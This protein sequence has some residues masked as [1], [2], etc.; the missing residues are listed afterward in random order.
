M[1]NYVLFKTSKIHTKFYGFDRIRATLQSDFES[2]IRSVYIQ[3]AKKF[4]WMHIESVTNRPINTIIYSLIFFNPK[5]EYLIFNKW[6]AVWKMQPNER[7][8]E[9][10]NKRQS[11]IENTKLM[12]TSNWIT[13]TID[14]CVA[15]KH[16]FDWT[17]IVGMTKSKSRELKMKSINS[18]GMWMRAREGEKYVYNS[19]FF[20]TVKLWLGMFL[21][22]FGASKPNES[23]VYSSRPSS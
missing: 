21:F 13:T 17:K 4:D 3:R 7:E 12:F 20:F 11:G 15:S 1:W 9:R 8:W 14:K 10:K 22:L 18:I 6:I 19:H 5:L 16:R 2:P 23:D